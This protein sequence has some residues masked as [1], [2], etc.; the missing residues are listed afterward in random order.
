VFELID[1]SVNSVEHQLTVSALCC[2]AAA[3]MP[4]AGFQMSGAAATT[5]LSAAGIRLAGAM[6]STGCVL[7]VSNLNEEVC[8]V[9]CLSCTQPVP[10]L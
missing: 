9:L 1:N 7:L 4:L 8:K 5:A 3:G 10:S 2:I 6:G